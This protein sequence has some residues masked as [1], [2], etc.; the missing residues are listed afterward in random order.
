MY[1]LFIDFVYALARFGLGHV[2]Q[3]LDVDLEE[4][5]VMFTRSSEHG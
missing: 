5:R 4:F 3:P 1:T 2:G